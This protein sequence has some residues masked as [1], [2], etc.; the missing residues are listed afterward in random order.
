MKTTSKA[1][2]TNKVTDETK[3]TAIVFD[4]LESK[5]AK[6]AI[7]AFFADY[8]KQ[9]STEWNGLKAEDTAY[10]ALNNV[11][12]GI[13]GGEGLKP[14]E[15]IIK[16]FTKYIDEN[17][18]PCNRKKD[19]NGQVYFTA[20]NMSGNN[21]KGILKRACLNCIESNRKGNRFEQIIVK[22]ISK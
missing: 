14:Y 11:I 16:Y 6:N 5:T 18:T 3:A 12:A 20:Y 9:L 8:E 19:E 13:A 17:G 1:I 4:N 21:A 10:K 22:P 15:F 2:V 7:K